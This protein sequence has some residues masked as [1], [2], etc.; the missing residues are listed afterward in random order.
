MDN[1][2]QQLPVDRKDCGPAELLVRA[3]RAGDIEKVF[4]NTKV[5][6]Q[7]D[8]NYL[9]RAILP[10]DVVKQSLA[11]MIDLIDYPNFKDIGAHRCRIGAGRC[12]LDQTLVRNTRREYTVQRGEQQALLWL[13]RRA[14]VDGP[15]GRL[16]LATLFNIQAGFGV[17]R[18]RPQGRARHEG[19][20]REATAGPRPRRGR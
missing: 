13:Q 16:S 9:Y 1:A 10:R 6:R 2:E 14:V 7:T 4:P 8:S 18:Q 5:I 15:G 3:R 12:A 19:V 11:A 20:F 17:G